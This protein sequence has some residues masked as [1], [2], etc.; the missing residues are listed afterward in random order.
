VQ[1]AGLE[2]STWIL[3]PSCAVPDVVETLAI[4]PPFSDDAEQTWTAK[5]AQVLVPTGTGW[6]TASHPDEQINILGSRHIRRIQG[7]G[8]AWTVGSGR[9]H[10]RR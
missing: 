1:L 5:F 8:E 4:S 2:A 7:V 6:I 9:G 10:G 3:L